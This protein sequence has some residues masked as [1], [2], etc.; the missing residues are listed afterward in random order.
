MTEDLDSRC[1]RLL[2]LLA[3][4]DGR[5]DRRDADVFHVA[6]GAGLKRARLAP[7]VRSSLIA[8]SLIEIHAETIRL[9]AAGRAA[10]AQTSNHPQAWRLQHGAVKLAPEELTEGSIGALIDE[11]ESPLAW[12]YRRK[13]QGGARL[14][15]E[16]EFKAGERLR[17]DFTKAG[18]M[19][20]VT[21]NWRDMA[22]SGG[23]GRGGRAEMTDIA[24]A[25]RDRVNKALAALGPELAGVALDVCCFL[26]GLETIESDRQ[27]PQRSAKVVLKLALKGLARHYGIASEA[28]GN[29]RASRMQH[30]GADGYRPD[31]GG[32]R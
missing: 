16:T 8:R 24:L 2:R 23:G 7:D 13:G 26:K 18:L 21:S 22:S 19:P 27:W 4:A 5:F 28:T 15:D 31:I 12:L 32:K 6:D 10:V 17:H 29:D 20:T 14:V 30:W 3:R 11:A 25:A 9:T 1:D